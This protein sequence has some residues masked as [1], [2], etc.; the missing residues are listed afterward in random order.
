MCNHTLTLTHSYTSNY[1][2]VGYL[3]YTI[4]LICFQHAILAHVYK[5]NAGFFA[6]LIL[7]YVCFV[8]KKFRPIQFSFN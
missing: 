6:K 5:S 3:H 8:F 1:V 7:E 4:Q 2:C